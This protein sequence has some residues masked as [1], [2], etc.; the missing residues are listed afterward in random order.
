MVQ[1]SYK[2]TYQLCLPCLWSGSIYGLWL[3]VWGSAYSPTF[4]V[5]HVQDS[6]QLHCLPHRQNVVFC[7]QLSA[8]KICWGSSVYIAEVVID[9]KLKRKQFLRANLI[10]KQLFGQTCKTSQTITII[11]QKLGFMQFGMCLMIPC[12]VTYYPGL[13]WVPV[14]RLRGLFKQH[15]LVHWRATLRMCNHFHIYGCLYIIALDLRIH[16]MCSNS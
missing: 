8:N 14:W 1:F 7:H 16:E 6:L 4:L 5:V 3:N 15:Q 12:C 10:L 11:P 13:C 2:S 9:T